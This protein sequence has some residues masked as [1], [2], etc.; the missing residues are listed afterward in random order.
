VLLIPSLAAVMLPIAMR[1]GRR[2]AATVI[3]NQGRRNAQLSR[4]AQCT[5][6]RLQWTIIF[7][8]PTCAVS[9]LPFSFAGPTDLTA[10]SPCAAAGAASAAHGRQL[11]LQ[12][13]PSRDAGADEASIIISVA[14]VRRIEFLSTADGFAPSPGRSL[15]GGWGMLTPGDRGRDGGSSMMKPSAALRLWRVVGNDWDRAHLSHPLVLDAR[16]RCRFSSLARPNLATASIASRP[17]RVPAPALLLF[18]P[19]RSMN[20]HRIVRAVG[21]RAQFAPQ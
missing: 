8:T 21:P 15:E 5:A 7:S 19:T 13:T 10:A 18:P 6:Y 2:H 11:P 16:V 17:S 3:T 1:Q 9:A 20:D 12:P 14:L 4:R